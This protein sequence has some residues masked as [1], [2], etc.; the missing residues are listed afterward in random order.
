METKEKCCPSCF[1]FIILSSIVITCVALTFIGCDPTL[2]W[3]DT[4]KMIRNVLL[5]YLSIALLCRLYVESRLKCK[6]LKR[7]HESCS[8]YKLIQFLCIIGII[9]N[10][11]DTHDVICGV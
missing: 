1:K 3:Y 7:N 2:I 4:I 11:D 9:G 5:I 10:E 6:D 8:Y